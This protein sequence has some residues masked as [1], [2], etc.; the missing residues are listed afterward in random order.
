M[1][2]KENAVNIECHKCFKEF[3]STKCLRPSHMEIVDKTDEWEERQDAKRKLE[4]S[5]DILKDD[6][7]KTIPKREPIIAI[8]DNELGLEALGSN[9][10]IKEDKFRTGYE[11]KTCDG[12]GTTGN[13][14]KICNGERIL[15]TF[16]NVT[17]PVPYTED[18]LSS[19]PEWKREK[20]T[21]E[22]T[23]E[24][25]IFDANPVPSITKQA[26]CSAC[27]RRDAHGNMIPTGME[28]C[29]ACNGSGAF[30]FVPEESMRRPTSGVIVSLG[31]DV[32]TLQKGDRILYS[33]FTGHAI[34]F[35]QN[36]VFR[37]MHEHECFTK[38]HG[39]GDLQKR[40]K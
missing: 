32:K 15:E 33:N 1:A 39:I 38:L 6:Y 8:I 9:L 13:K 29:L 27:M 36:V 12:E 19:W 37:I 16:I 25:R 18:E 28:L 26:A 5:K 34:N 23:E 10:I 14:C 3:G 40:L 20:L 21:I 11:C 35:K 7:G 4:K 22:R 30:L 31:P 24:I 2:E 17:R